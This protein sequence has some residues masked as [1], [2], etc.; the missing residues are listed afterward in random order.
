MDSFNKK[1]NVMIRVLSSVDR[2]INLLSDSF[3]METKINS[4]QTYE[5][6]KT[7]CSSEEYAYYSRNKIAIKNL[8][9]MI[10]M[11]LKIALFLMIIMAFWV[12]TKLIAI[13]FS[14]INPTWYILI[15]C[16]LT[17]SPSLAVLVWKF[18]Y[19]RLAKKSNQLRNMISFSLDLKVSDIVSRADEFEGKYN[20]LVNKHNLKINKSERYL[21]MIRSIPDS[22]ICFNELSLKQ[23]KAL[24]PLS[25]NLVVETFLFM[26]ILAVSIIT[27]VVDLQSNINTSADWVT[28]DSIILALALGLG[29][30]TGCFMGDKSYENAVDISTFR[31]LFYSYLT[32]AK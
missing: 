12:S 11:I 2:P 31:Y 17:L 10:S 30:C 24:G 13:D 9:P 14:K 4:N 20:I 15:I 22:R 26:A 21:K 18:K 8:C 5:D 1:F 25:E 27:F 23:S 6:L 3:S 29:I 16:E 7:R 28:S 32:D 19:Q